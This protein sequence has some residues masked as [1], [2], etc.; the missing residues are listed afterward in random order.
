MKNLELKASES[1][2]ESSIL[3][4]KCSIDNLRSTS[5]DENV[6]SNSEAPFPKISASL[7]GQRVL[8]RIQCELRKGVFV[9]VLSEMEKH[10][11]SVISTSVMPFAS[12]SHNITV[13]AEATEVP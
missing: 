11:L 7:N 3:A 10:H 5:A 8:V 12:S 9:R 4:E 2:V 1:D 13:T 6:I